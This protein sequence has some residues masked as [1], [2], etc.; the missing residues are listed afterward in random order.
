MFYA[1]ERSD[2]HVDSTGLFVGR[3]TTALG[4]LSFGPEVGYRFESADGRRTVE[5]YAFVTGAYD[6][7]GSTDFQVANNVIV[8]SA[9]LGARA[10][11]GI[12]LRSENLTGRI[13]VSYDS[14]GRN[15]EDSWTLHGRIGRRF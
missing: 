2:A 1:G 7:A 8:T 12:D 6:F 4:R 11:G 15:G 5:P 9:R 13:G 3:L 14:L 10:G